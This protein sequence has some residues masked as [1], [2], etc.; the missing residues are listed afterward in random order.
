MNR[1]YRIRSAEPR[2]LAGAYEVCLKTGDDG[3]DATGFYEDPEALG[4]IFVGPYILLEPELAFVL[5]DSEGIC[6]YALGALDSQAFYQ[7]YL[8]EWVPALQRKYPA[9]TGNPAGWT[10]T[11]RIYHD[12]HHPEVYCPEPCADY[13]SHL[14]I[15][16]LPRAQGRGWGRRMME[17]LLAAL[18]TRGSPGV[19]LGVGQVNERA[20]GFYRKLGFAELA[21]RQDVL[22]LG[23]RL[24]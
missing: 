11:E 1:T 8:R 21:R 4:R 23:R 14:H 22:Y 15:D 16:L 2:D 13:P 19:H 9:P 20:I 17:H 3:Q 7:K 10:R 6:G 12:Y 18:R 5:E 24:T